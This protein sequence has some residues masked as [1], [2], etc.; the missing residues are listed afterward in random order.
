[1][2][3]PLSLI[4]QTTPDGKWQFDG[5]VTDVFE[6][7]LERSIP[8]YQV[9]RDSVTSL[10][11]DIVRTSGTSVVDLGCSRGSALAPFVYQHCPH[12]VGV[13][14]SEPMLAAAQFRFE[15]EIARGQVDIRRCDLRTDYPEEE[16][17]LTLAV[18]VLQFVPIEYRQQIVRNA[19]KHTRPGGALIVVEKV[20]GDTTEIDH[21][22]VS[23]YLQMKA[24]N[25]Y[26]H[27]QIE[28]KRLSLEGVLVPI[29]ASWNEQ[30]LRHAG[31]EHVD[32]FW[33]WMNF[34]GWLALREA[35]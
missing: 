27:E 3:D 31:F 12:C 15:E 17:W 4:D 8:Q 28:R 24:T 20:L 33:R 13:E 21:R 16:T 23:E 7:M 18:L 19:Y 32:C 25:G 35:P 6:N 29:T 1:M 30:L 14:V 11:L 2:D 5:D 10:G 22:L 26:S 9:M 34:A